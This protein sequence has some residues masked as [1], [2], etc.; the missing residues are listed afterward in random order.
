M[1]QLL[2]GE[3]VPV[4]RVK[5]HGHAATSSWRPAAKLSQPHELASAIC[6]PLES[7]SSG[8]VQLVPVGPSEDGG[9][10][11]DTN[12]LAVRATRLA[13]EDLVASF[14]ASSSSSRGRALRLQLII[15]MVNMNTGSY[16]QRLISLLAC[17]K[18]EPTSD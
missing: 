4:E 14:S 9:R 8:A 5:G 15:D 11:P 3:K 7:P 18:N 6:E 17:C 10:T 1:V 12:E 16:L 13:N 2:A